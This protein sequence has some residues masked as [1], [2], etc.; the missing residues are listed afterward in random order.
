MVKSYQR[1]TTILW[2]ESIQVLRDWRTLAMTF[3]LPLV[4]LLLFALAVHLTVNHIPLALFD[5]SKDAQSRALVQSLVNSSYFDL[6]YYLGSEKEVLDALDSGQARAAMIIPPDFARHVAQG[7]ANVLFLLDGSDAFTVQ[8]GYSAANVVAQQ[9]ALN[10]ALRNMEKAGVSSAAASA[11]ITTLLQI[12]YNPDNKDLIFILPGLVGI[13]IQM[14]AIGNAA[15]VVVREREAGIL[16][17][18]L[19]TPI[20]PLELMVGKLVPNLVV[21][22]V[23]VLLM[24]A[25]GVW[26][27]QVPFKGS[28]WLF[29]GLAIL[30]VMSSLGL[31]MLVS[32]VS[33]TQRQA[34]QFSNV[35]TLFSM[36]LTGFLYPL[37][38]MPAVPRLIGELL[39]LTYFLRIVRG[40]ITKGVGL[41]LLW[42]DALVLV[43]YGFGILL[44]AS[45]T[46]RKR[47]D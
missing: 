27:F 21:T 6:Q 45:L 9:Y 13:V 32:T 25:V 43:V 44:L 18:L 22:L 42:Q 46:F 29:F 20:R 19:T 3:F 35:F 2:K 7:N 16:E 10:I 8:S 23:D 26:F 41:Q 4:E 36:V 40:I 11:P 5:Q 38:T 17:Q 39:P 1:L 31:G 14:L 15:L 47:L 37:A 24:V 12:L 28:F 30:F 33:Q 34:Q